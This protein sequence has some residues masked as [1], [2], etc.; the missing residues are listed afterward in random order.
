MSSTMARQGGWVQLEQSNMR[1]AL[2]MSDMAK[3]GF[4]R[5]T[6]EEMQYLIDNHRRKV[7]E[8]KKRGVV[9]LGH[10]MANAGIERH[11][12]MVLKYLMDGRFPC[13]NGTAKIYSDTQKAQRHG[14]S[15]RQTDA[16]SGQ[17]LICATC[18]T[19][20][21]WGSSKFRNWMCATRICVY[22]DISFQLS[23]FQ[24]CCIWHGS[25]GRSRLQSRLAGWW[26]SI[27][28]F[29]L[30]LLNSNAAEMCFADVS[31]LFSKPES[32]NEHWWTGTEFFGILLSTISRHFTVYFKE[33]IYMCS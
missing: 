33:Y 21:H 29:V 10:R 25:Q 16:I 5:A 20:W 18:A 31:S 14:C 32:E 7:S 23:V 11:P 30:N 4:S 26:W 13:Q 22:T 28:W 6:I 2:Y 24:S 3:G 15:C 8:E 9:F 17:K 19:W 1:L 27:H 12:A